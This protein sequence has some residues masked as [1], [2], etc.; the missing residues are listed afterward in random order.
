MIVTVKQEDHHH[1]HHHNHH[2]FLGEDGIV[3]ILKMEEVIVIDLVVEVVFMRMIAILGEIVIEIEIEIDMRD[4]FEMT[5]IDMNDIHVIVKETG[6]ETETE[7][8]PDLEVDTDEIV[9]IWIN[10]T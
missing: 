2:L 8:G 3:D 9:G 7:I 10:I 1:H 6:I 5:V 4:R